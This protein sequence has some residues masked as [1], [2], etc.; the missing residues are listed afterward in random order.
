MKTKNLIYLSTLS[1]A[2][3]F[4]SCKKDKPEAPAA[5]TTTYDNGVFITNEGP[6]QTGTGTVSF[7]SRSSGTVSNDIFQT[8]NGYPLGNVVQSMTI[9]NGKG[10]IVVNNA[11]KA[12]VIDGSSFASDGEIKNL[13]NPRYFLGINS[14]KGYISQWNS[15]GAGCIKVINLSTNAITASIPTGL[16]AE[17]MLKVGNNVYV[18]CSGGFGND[19]VVSVI[20]ATTD[21]FIKNIYVGANPTYIQEDENGKIWV[22]CVGQF[23]SAYTS[24]VKPASLARINAST[25]TVDLSLPFAS[26][27]SQPSN[28]VMNSTQTTLFYS[29]N[30]GVYSQD[31]TSST[32]NMVAKISRSF[33]SLGIDPTNN[34]FYCA[35][36]GDNVSDGKVLR[37]NTTGVVVDSF[38]VGVIPGNFFFK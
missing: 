1:L 18:A 31:V 19:S 25:N 28:L 7:Y 10:Y 22:L 21:T 5:T 26:T 6:F 8:K 36:A 13:S 14:S 35:D 27:I 20:D 4:T 12:E 23:N 33:F 24:L 9:F 3:A 37:Y 15:T 16:G 29:Y 32:L 17:N 11:G 38:T 34:F 2:I 30:G